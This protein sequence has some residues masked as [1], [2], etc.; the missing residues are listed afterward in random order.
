MTDV[1]RNGNYESGEL[2]DLDGDGKRLE[3]VPTILATEWWEL[4]KTADGKPG[5]IQHVVDAD[6]KKHTFG[7][8]CG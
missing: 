7:T 8:W 2:W 3:I 4:G 5:L 6:D 1:R